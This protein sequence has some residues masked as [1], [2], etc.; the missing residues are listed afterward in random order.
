M[1]PFGLF[2]SKKRVSAKRFGQI[3]ANVLR[4][5]ISIKTNR[6]SILASQQYFFDRG[7]VFNEPRFVN[8]LKVMYFSQVQFIMIDG[9]QL[10]ID[11]KAILDNF[12]QSSHGLIS[13][14]DYLR[15]VQTSL[16]MMASDQP[17]T[18]LSRITAQNYFGDESV[19]MESVM[20]F[21]ASVKAFGSVLEEL[22]SDYFIK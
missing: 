6:D 4:E 5:T 9:F 16:N 19:G 1:A 14:E 2:G 8:E 7:W 13:N 3:L 18:T 15:V 21:G 22:K 20:F 17:L 10:V 11:K 12:I